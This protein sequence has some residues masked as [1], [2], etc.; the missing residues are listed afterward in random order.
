[1][2][3][4]DQYIQE[5]SKLCQKQDFLII[6]E[7]RAGAKNEVEVRK[8][9]EIINICKLINKLDVDFFGVEFC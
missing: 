3:T 6:R 4:F 8:N 5:K 7:Y 1:M 9:P 2:I